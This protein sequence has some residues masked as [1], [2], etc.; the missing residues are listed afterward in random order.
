MNRH[1]NSIAVLYRF[2][3]KEIRIQRGEIHISNECM[4]VSLSDHNYKSVTNKKAEYNFVVH[5]AK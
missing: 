2:A 5:K 4:H 3:I 1:S